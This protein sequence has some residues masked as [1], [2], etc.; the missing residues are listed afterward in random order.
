MSG[1]A[2]TSHSNHS[3]SKLFRRYKKIAARLKSRVRDHFSLARWGERQAT[4]HLRWQGL[5]IRNI[6]W[7][8]KSGEIDIVAQDHA[9]LVIV[10]VKSRRHDV[11]IDYRPED[12]VHA[13]KRTQLGKLAALYQREYA[14]DLRRKRL[15][16]VRFDLIAI[17]SAKPSGLFWKVQ[18][19]R[20]QKGDSINVR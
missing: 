11:A 7:R 14:L 2:K 9:T 10:E 15:R 1:S 18:D 17:E 3:I 6:N 12:A 20:W 19:L 13:E 8:C 4:K 16:H 5:W